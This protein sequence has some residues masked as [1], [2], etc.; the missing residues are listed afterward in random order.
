[1]IDL[2]R[3]ECFK[4]HLCKPFD[5][6]FCALKSLAT[7]G[8]AAAYELY[9]SAV[10]SIEPVDVGF[11]DEFWPL[12][13]GLLTLLVDDLAFAALSFFLFFVIFF[14]SSRIVVLILIVWKLFDRTTLKYTLLS[15]YIV[16]QVTGI[17]RKNQFRRKKKQ[18]NFWKALRGRARG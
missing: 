5:P 7:P 9:L 3:L 11:V 6:F 4:L 17:L 8:T 14:S 16:Y 13:T 2:L 12:D 18:P 1:M 15:P 10:A